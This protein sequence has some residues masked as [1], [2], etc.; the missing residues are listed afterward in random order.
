[1]HLLGK[2]KNLATGL[3]T[4]TLTLY[5][6][7][8]DPRTPWCAKMLIACV[9]AYAL[10]PIDLIPD[11]IPLLGYL[12]DL[13]LLPIGIYLAL[14]LIPPAVLTESRQKASGITGELPKSRIAAI[15]IVILWVTAIMVVGVIL[16]KLIGTESQELIGG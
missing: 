16:T 15:V 3:K 6:A 9:V 5:F 7:A 1:L 11:F 10:S 2:L 12:D 4:E 14:K 13:L 8:R